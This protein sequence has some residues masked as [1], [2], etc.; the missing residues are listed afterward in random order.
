MPGGEIVG[1]LLGGGARPLAI[2]A[3][4]VITIGRDPQNTLCISD[5]LASRSHAVVECQS[6]SEMFVRDLGSTNG[7]WLNAD[8]LKPQ[9]RTHLKSGDAIRIGGKLISFSGARQAE[10]KSHGTRVNRMDT[11]RDGLFY[12]NGQVVEIPDPGS[13]DRFRD[14]MQTQAVPPIGY[15][16]PSLSGSLSEQNLAQIIQYLHTNSKTGELLVKG[17]NREGLIVFER[18]QIVSAAA[19]DRNGVVAIYA[20]ARERVGSFTFKA[21]ENVGSRPRNVTDPVMQ[22]VFECCK[23]M[24]ETELAG[25]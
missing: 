24:D 23:R 21:L 19:G 20:V 3:G 10:Q 15:V 12:R 25:H 17:K 16:E 7:T 2:Y 6:N 13:E 22:I 14:V 1:Y 8:R 5:V 4:D 18:G 9:L 11:V